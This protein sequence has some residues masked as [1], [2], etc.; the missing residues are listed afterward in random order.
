L[1]FWSCSDS[2]SPTGDGGNVGTGDSDAP[3]VDSV[4]ALSDR[5]IEVY[6]DE[7]VEKSSAENRDYYLFIRS[8]IFRAASGGESPAAWG[9]TL[10]A[11]AAVLG[12]DG[13]T[14]SIHIDAYM[15]E[16]DY[17]YYI[18][19]VRDLAGNAITST[20]TGTFAGTLAQD[21]KPPVVVERSPSSGATG[22]GIRQPVVVR[23]SEPMYT[24]E[25]L[26]SFSWTGGGGS[27]PASV[28]TDDEVVFVFQPLV[29]MLENTTYTFTLSNTAIDWSGN[30]LAETSWSFTTAVSPDLTPPR[31]VSMTPADGA[32][33]VPVT[34]NLVL[35]FSEP[36][37]QE[38]LNEII[39][40]PSP[41]DGV[42]EWSQDGTTVTFDP[43]QNL[44]TNT[45][46]TL[47]IPPGGIQDIAGNP[48]T[49]AVEVQFTTSSSFPQGRISGTILGDPSSSYASDPNGALVLAA[50][51]F[52]FDAEDPSIEG[53]DVVGAGGTYNIDRLVDGGYYLHAIL[54]SNG[55]G[56]IDPGTGDATG[57]AGIVLPLD[58]TPDM[59][60]VSGGQHM[61]DV[62]FQLYDFSVINGYVIYVG[63]Q[64]ASE[65][66]QYDYSVGLFKVEG[67]DIDN[68]PDA[69]FGV[70][71]LDIVR[72]PDFHVGGF[73]NAID[74]STYYVGAF[75]DIG[76]DGDYTPGVDPGG[77][78]MIND[79]L[80][81][82]TVE[83]G[84][85]VMGIVIE[86]EDPSAF[87]GRLRGKNSGSAWIK[88]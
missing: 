59:V 9:D 13:K 62:D 87:V 14:V 81:P 65:L 12:P 7:P 88:R 19:G 22:V 37:Q 17:D 52:L 69:D 83:N 3:G 38:G 45:M 73:E 32:T 68:L 28:D 18:T 6:F 61:Q 53:T 67:F 85:D 1:A 21:D 80:A 54:D 11:Q 35:V 71:G 4:V 70:E 79:L 20:L 44:L 30:P 39:M 29:D 48:M 26:S 74:D 47:V 76:G 36:I 64:Y 66:Y 82:V 75:L 10:Q 25:L 8:D 42:A 43:D 58:R 16:I 5:Q 86:L 78:Y 84:S 60:I 40:T 49:E 27:V 46:Y 72:E 24:T 15:N 33:N 77:F 2:D 34:T 57:V 31:L 51:E 55:D 56:E 50:S 63:T 23:F 41:G